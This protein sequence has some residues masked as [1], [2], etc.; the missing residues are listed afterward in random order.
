MENWIFFEEGCVNLSKI[1]AV[2]KVDD[3]LKPPSLKF[4][5]KK[6][7]LILISFLSELSRNKNLEA[8]KTKLTNIL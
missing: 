5:T 6:G 7:D 2:Q 8:I 4:T 1:I 3:I